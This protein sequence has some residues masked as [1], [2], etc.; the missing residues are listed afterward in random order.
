MIDINQIFFIK[1]LLWPIAHRK[2]GLFDKTGLTFQIIFVTSSRLEFPHNQGDVSKQ[3]C[4][5]RRTHLSPYVTVDC[6][7]IA[8]PLFLHEHVSMYS[9]R[10]VDLW[11]QR[12]TLAPNEFRTWHPPAKVFN[13][14]L[15]WKCLLKSVSS[16][17]T[18]RLIFSP[19]TKQWFCTVNPPPNFLTK[20]SGI[21]EMFWVFCPSKRHWQF[22][23]T[24]VV[25]VF[26]NIT[27]AF[28][29]YLSLWLQSSLHDHQCGNIFFFTVCTD[30]SL[31]PRVESL[32]RVF[33]SRKCCVSGESVVARWVEL[34]TRRSSDRFVLIRTRLLSVAWKRNKTW[35]SF[36]ESKSQNTDL[37]LNCKGELKFV[38]FVLLNKCELKITLFNE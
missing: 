26:F 2:R 31:W 4:G 3:G 16:F 17:W 32:Y 28:F 8:L 15:T 9:Q 35:C 24:H 29:S 19:E 36:T 27:V 30:H 14:F 7:H 10:D 33:H 21:C 6:S 23:L 38:I 20:R 18:C 11:T 25:I 5:I 1:F 22:S 13:D 34:G 12:K 37:S